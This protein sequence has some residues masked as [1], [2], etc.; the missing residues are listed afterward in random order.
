VVVAS[1]NSLEFRILGPLE[2]LEGGLPLELGGLK[3][4]ALL[5]VLLLEANH[6]VASGRLIEA[7]WEEDPPDTAQKALQVYI[8]QL[9]KLLG[10]ERLQTRAPGYCLCLAEG[11]LD[12][13]H[14]QRVQEE[15]RLH[16]ALALW[17]GPP[18][19]EFA[20]QRFA[21]AEIA[22]LEELRL[23][24]L[25]ER[26]ERDL[27][28]GR[29]SEI[30]GE[31][32]S[33]ARRYPLRER[34]RGQLM[35]ALYRS[36]RQA[37]ALESYQ[38]ARLKLV[39]D[40]GIEPGRSLRTL[41]AA[42]LNQAATLDLVIDASA[43]RK[44]SPAAPSTERVPASAGEMRKTVTVVFVRFSIASRAG[45]VLDPE[46][47]R[48]LTGRAFAAVERA[49]ES[50]GGLIE[51]LASEALTAVFGLPLVHEDDAIRGMRA[52]AEVR[53]ALVELASELTVER[54]LELE[55]HIGISTGEVVTGSNA[56]KE[57]RT[58]GEPLGSAS[59]LAL[60]A[61]RGEILFDEN[62]WQLVR[63]SVLAEPADNAW[64]LLE[65]SDA[66]TVSPRRLDSPMVGRTR[67]RRRLND[68]FEQAVSDN[69][70]Q[71]FTVLG[72]AGV[73]KSR[74]VQEFLG[75]VTGRGLVAGG[76]CLPYGEG[77]TFWPLLEVVKELV[78][79]SD[80][81]SPDDARTKLAAALEG[82]HDVELLALRIAEMIGLVEGTGA[83][84]EGFIAI[85]VLLES[86]ARTEPLVVVFDDIH[87]GES[88]FLDLIEHLAEWTH[89][90]PLLLICLARPELLDVRPGWGGGKLNATAALLEPLSDRECTQLIENLV[91]RAEL[92]DE[93]GARIAEAAE[94]NP[95][96]VEEMLSMLIDDGLLVH[97]EGRWIVTGDISA[98]RVPPTIHA[99]LAAR[100]DQL[101]P[102]ERAVIE[103]AAVAGKVFQ[104]GSVAALSSE[105]LR[106][107]V[108]RALGTLVRKELIRPERARLGERSYHFRHLL[109]RDAAYASISKDARAEL[110]QHFARWLEHTTG[111]RATEYEEVLG[112]H[113][114][115]AYRCRAE[116]GAVDDA[117]RSLAREAA[118]RLGKAGRRAF[119]RSDAPA[120][121]NLISRAVALLK[122]EDPLRV[123]L[124]PNTRVVQ[125]MDVDM[126]WADRA[127][128]EA[129]ETAATTG[130][131]R[132]AAHALVQRGLLRLFTEWDVTPSELIDSA[133]RS[134]GAF[135]EL[136]DE[137]GE[138]RAWRLKAQA[139]YLGRQAGLCAEASERALEHVR[140]AGDPFEER[141][142]VEWLSIALFLGPMPAAEA[143][144]RC[145]RL[146][147]EM[148][149]Q[150]S[151]QAMIMV[152]EST[153]V[154]M[155]G[156]IAEAKRLRSRARAMLRDLD[157]WIWIASF[158]W[159]FIALSENDPIAA[160]RELRPGYEALKQ[161]KSQSHFSSL[162]HALG[163]ALYV[164]GR[165]DEA[166]RL[167]HECEAASRPNDVHSQI[168]WRSTRAKI[169]ARRGQ[170]GAA[171]LLAREAV[172][173][174]FD[175]DFYPAHAEALMDLAEVLDIAGDANGATIATEAAIRLWELKG[176]VLATRRARARL[177]ARA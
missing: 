6:V 176:N 132:L 86:L 99:L 94:G 5:A 148:V 12:L 9:R 115:Q 30:I 102:D 174:A 171:E 22:R 145:E 53:A 8:S 90:A 155:Q 118:E 17:R 130:D 27:A 41:H 16:E 35:L 72:P 92:T 172:A 89:D 137:L 13:S 37:E 173:F 166:E 156:K 114:E 49:I 52:A 152:G 96:F 58:T 10:K 133:E 177:Q 54:S 36:G 103:R 153:L 79:L 125:G 162:A 91:G 150:P 127:L 68:A 1:A 32:E 42:I 151:V 117:A 159:S 65:V 39:E 43:A 2:V 119:L 26:I 165:Y 40:L 60:V 19:A 33:A 143:A 131:R 64:R 18:L 38:D 31:L 61:K 84:E 116:L 170:R 59:R 70:C 158:W 62:A 100:L 164:Q 98:V 50:H 45:D 34:L 47:L 110:H 168:L 83:A 20:D 11:E 123:E 136:G 134:I 28:E 4:R 141:E 81:E 55:F 23:A 3:Q 15:G 95:L 107:A 120:G 108:A 66:A 7:L 138:A 46:A 154:A 85:R 121:V 74:L 73:G 93:V 101:E 104:E 14:F 175:S 109:I 139:H 21:Q 82:E 105:R 111:E 77:I 80:S 128:T 149:G 163:N 106:P 126:S 88:T 29:A 144:R 76:R 75:D 147:E 160:E 146:R 51:S 140:R 44:E 157:E 56:G 161:L 87:W 67:E 135:A 78:G 124:I 112:Y 24:C 113:L 63:G 169:L 142:I 71:L 25:E 48:R 57:S 69:S 167:T 97:S 129:V 122:P